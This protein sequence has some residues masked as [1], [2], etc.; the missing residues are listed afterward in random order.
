MKFIAG[1]LLI[2][3]GVLGIEQV[4]GDL[5]FVGVPVIFLGSALAGTGSRR[6]RAERRGAIVTGTALG[7]VGIALYLSVPSMSAPFIGLCLLA[8][9]AAIAG[10][11]MRMPA[12]V[13]DAHS[14]R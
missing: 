4:P 7:A 11:A 13:V 9:G 1:L 10:L 3:G 5:G 8:A 6:T 12:V 14:L 2:V